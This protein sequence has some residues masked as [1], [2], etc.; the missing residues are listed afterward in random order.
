ME[1]IANVRMNTLSGTVTNTSYS[2]IERVYLSGGSIIVEDG[3]G[4]VYDLRKGGRACA[5]PTTS[6]I[7][8]MLRGVDG[9]DGKDGITPDM[10]DYYDKEV[11]DAKLSAKQ[12]VIEDL[13]TMRANASKGATALQSIPSEYVTER[14]LGAMGL[15]TIEQLEAKQ[16]TINDLDTIRSGAAKG[17]TALQAHQDISGKQDK[18]IS[19][20]TIKTINGSSL[21]GSGNISVS[22]VK[23][24]ISVTLDYAL[25][26]QPNK[27]YHIEEYV[28]SDLNIVGTTQSERACDEYE[29]HFVTGDTA[30]NLIL[31]SRVKWVNG[32]VPTLE[33][34]T[35][36]ELLIVAGRIGTEKFQKARLLAFK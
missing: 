26:L 30:G 36:Y 5:T 28:T 14:R 1:R 21:L 16:D 18:L 23:D 20:S 12:D 22:G 10:G 33:A 3:V 25:N 4:N 19:G 8:T 27:I 15:A 2:P 29:V 35:A 6:I 9:Q 24:V 11:V 32:V 31:P 7:A 17:A 34:N 13:A